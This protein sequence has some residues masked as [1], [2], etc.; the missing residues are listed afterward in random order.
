MSHNL[1]KIGQIWEIEIASNKMKSSITT[2]K[3]QG[4]YEYEKI[5]HFIL[6]VDYETIA[7]S[8]LNYYSYKCLN[9]NGSISHIPEWQFKGAKKIVDNEL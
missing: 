6:I 8:Q 2:M 5:K 7:G 4:F 3:S 9:Q 1:P